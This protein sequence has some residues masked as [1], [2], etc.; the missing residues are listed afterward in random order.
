VELRQ[1]TDFV[2]VAEEPHF[3]RA[4]ERL[5]L[6]LAL[7]AQTKTLDIQIPKV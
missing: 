6:T 7:S 4:A 3:G 2:A 5:L 1:L